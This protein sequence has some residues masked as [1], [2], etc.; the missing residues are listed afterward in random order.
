[1][2]FRSSA[3]AQKANALEQAGLGMGTMGQTGQ[4]MRLAST[5]AL[6]T[7]GG[8][9]QTIAQNK[10]L[11]P[12]STLSNLSSLLQGYSIPTSTTTTLCTSPLAGL[13]SVGTGI[14]ALLQP[15]SK[16]GKNLLCLVTG[17]SSFG[18]L[19]CKAFSYLKCKFGGGCAEGGSVHA[20]HG[21]LIHNPSGAY[22]CRSTK[23]R[24]GLPHGE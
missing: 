11:F 6:A 15:C 7:L 5:N 22:G 21:G 16:T 13:A 12:M 20:A 4:N 17:S 3:A 14:G 1:M 9:Q 19:A 8:Q 24:G 2:L 10:Q 18:N 23:H